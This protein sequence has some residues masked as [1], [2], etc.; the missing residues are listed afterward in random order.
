MENDYKEKMK[1]QEGIKGL[2]I[3]CKKLYREIGRGN[4][5]LMRAIMDDKKP[6]MSKTEIF[7]ELMTISSMAKELA[8]TVV[9]PIAD[10]SNV[11]EE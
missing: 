9:S 10:S 7:D 6:P 5:V 3:K 2:N 8:C 4:D 11:K 1:L